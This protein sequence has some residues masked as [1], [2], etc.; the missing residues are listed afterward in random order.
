[1]VPYGLNQDAFASMYQRKLDHLS[2]PM[3]RSLQRLLALPLDSDVDEAS[4]EIFLDDDGAAPTIWAYWRGRNNKVD[5]T[6][7]GLF[8]GRSLEVDV[9][10]SRLA[11]IDERYFTGPA[12]FPGHELTA[13]L[14]LRWFAEA[15]WKAGGWAYAVPATVAVHDFEF[16]GLLQLS[17]GQG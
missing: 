16:C 2:D 11:D 9:D 3:I 6:D 4:V 13:A 8:A 10:L 14:L 1:M 12:A 7:P 15:W 17:K 5:H